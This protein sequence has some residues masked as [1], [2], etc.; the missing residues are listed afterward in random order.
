M[1]VKARADSTT[2]TANPLPVADTDCAGHGRH[3]RGHGAADHHPVQGMRNDLTSVTKFVVIW[4]TV[5]LLPSTVQGMTFGTRDCLNPMS[6]GD[7][8]GLWLICI[9]AH[10]SS[11]HR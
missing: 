11:R 5:K 1:D 7:T 9:S 6:K 3:P 4:A 10:S 8:N 2:R